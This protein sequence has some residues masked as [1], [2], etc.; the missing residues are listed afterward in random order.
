[1]LKRPARWI[2]TAAFAVGT[3]TA[4]NDGPGP[5]EV[6]VPFSESLSADLLSGSLY[7]TNLTTESASLYTRTTGAHLVSRETPEAGTVTVAIVGRKGGTIS[8][9]D[10]RLEIPRKALSEDVEFRM[11]VLAGDNIIVNLSARSV[12]SGDPVS[13]FSVPLTLVL[14]YKSV[15]STGDVTRLRNV[16]LYLD[17]SS[18][19]VPLLSTLD[20][21]NKTIS[22]PISHF[23]QYGMAIE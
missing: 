23:S 22:S 1:M 14:G 4:C 21:K 7:D 19:L 17:S 9:G 18:Y 20:Q 3:L 10:H 11:E 2:T 5:T 8:A 13:W 15:F 12:S 16:Y 6:S